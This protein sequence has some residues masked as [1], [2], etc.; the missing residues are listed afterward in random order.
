MVVPGPRYKGL[1]RSAVDQGS[2][3]DLSQFRVF[4]LGGGGGGGQ[5][6]NSGQTPRQVQFSTKFAKMLHCSVQNIRK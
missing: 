6:S 4:F 2:L 1:R 5:G 3:F